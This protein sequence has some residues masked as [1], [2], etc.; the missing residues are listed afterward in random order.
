LLGP[1]NLKLK[2]VFGDFSHSR[3]RC[4]LR[5]GELNADFFEKDELL[6]LAKT[7]ELLE[8]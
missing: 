1:L 8:A 3:P 5:D 2:R 4:V 6:F 7:E